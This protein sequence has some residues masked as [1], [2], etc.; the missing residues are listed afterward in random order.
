MAN[1]LHGEFR[2]TDT[3]LEDILQIQD[4]SW[5]P[6]EYANGCYVVQRGFRGKK[7]RIKKLIT[8]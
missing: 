8:A 1:K 5:D 7:W 4:P 2:G 3:L 6:S